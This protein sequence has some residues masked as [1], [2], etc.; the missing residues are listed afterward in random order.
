MIFFV[1]DTHFDHTNI[2]KYCDRPFR[3]TDEMNDHMLKM[4]N[5]YVGPDDTVYFL[6]DLTFGRGRRPHDYWLDQ[7]NGSVVF[8]R[9]GHD[10]KDVMRNVTCDVFN[11]LVIN[12][13]LLGDTLLIHSP[14]DI[15]DWDGWIIHGHVHNNRPFLSV[16]NK[17]VNVSME[18]VDYRPVSLG[19]LQQ[20]II[21][22]R[23]YLTNND[24]SGSIVLR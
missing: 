13:P 12:L 11:S 15:V 3:T 7:L 1:S 4:W 9:G 5:L 2:I 17:S 24:K 23:G 6:G 16:G 19:V 18:R 21:K 14:H 8:I 22:A 20:E 10:T